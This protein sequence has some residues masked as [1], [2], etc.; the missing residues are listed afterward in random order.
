MTDSLD[1]T[2]QLLDKL[3]LEVVMLEPNDVQGLGGVLN[4]LEEVIGVFS[5][6]GE[7]ALVG[8]GTAIKSIVE[9]LVMDEHPEPEEGIQQIEKGASLFQELLRDS[10]NGQSVSDKTER[11]LVECGLADTA[12]S[13]DTGDDSKS[14][15]PETGDALV[16]DIAQDRELLDSF[17]MEAQEHLG[18]I[19]VNVLSLEQDPENLDTINAIFRPFHTIKGV[20]G[21][22]NLSDINRLAHQVEALLDDARNQK[23]A[24]N[25]AVTDLVLDAVDLM[26]AM[27]NHLKQ[28]IETGTFEPVDFGLEPFFDRIRKLQAPE[29]EGAETETEEMPAED[30]ADVGKLLIEKGVVGEPDIAEALEKQ[31]LPDGKG[32]KLGELLIADKKATAR[33]VAGAL[34]DQKRI[35]GGG[36]SE[37]KGVESDRI[38]KVATEKLDNMVD[39]VGELVITQDMLRE[40]ISVLASQSKSLYTNIGQLRRITAEIQRISMSMRMVPIKQTFQKMIRLVRDLSKKSG[41]KVMLEM[42]GEETEIDRNMVDEIYDPL[43]HMVRNSID[44]GIETPDERKAKGKPET[45]TVTL[46]AYHKG[47]NI[48][49]EISEDGK[50]LDRDKIINKAIERNLI[51]SNENMSDNEVYGLIFQPGF[52]TADKVTD[53][54]GRGVGM[55][56]VKR[57]ID[58]LRGGLDINSVK[59]QG[60]TILMKLPLTMAIIDGITVRAGDRNYIIPTVSVVESLRPDREDCTTVAGKGEMI[61]I[62]DSLYPL[63]R[64]HRFFDFEPVHDNPWE[65]IV[66]V[67]E[68][69]NK[70][71]CILVDELVGKQE[72]VIKS[73]GEQL[74][75]VKGMAGGAILAD[76]R[77]GLIL[78]VPGL[79]ELSE[80]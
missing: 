64:L 1:S 66:V 67:A 7:D 45:G 12:E 42:I 57:A 60:T 49:I 9:K 25:E 13:G 33:D 69:D 19:E 61:K 44:H 40:D 68:S 17:I 31:N 74:K 55:D 63:V 58:K 37:E 56:V 59:D 47:G 11:F 50:G 16:A 51:Q 26:N 71:K 23:L 36:G 80:N 29:A 41:K 62:R 53:V 5:Q 48:V 43:V 39:M 46:K 79:F 3:A 27:I 65:S 21:F 34:R 10:E 4:R 72:V 78:D 52:S 6:A 32:K 73:L 28:G 70:R 77:V 20:S 22:L 75:N 24:V 30:G 15:E 76:G 54:S 38:V 8:L 35:R 14:D 18:T 2:K